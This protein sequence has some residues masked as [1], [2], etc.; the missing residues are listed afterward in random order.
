[1]G[2]LAVI[3]LALVAVLFGVNR[4]TEEIENLV[5]LQD[6]IYEIIGE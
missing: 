5:N 3:I 2:R 1:M 4:L 6:N